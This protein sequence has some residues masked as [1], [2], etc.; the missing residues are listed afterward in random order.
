VFGGSPWCST[1]QYNLTF[2]VHD[3]T[4]PTTVVQGLMA[5]E[6]LEAIRQAFGF[7]LLPL[8]DDEILRNAGIAVAET[9]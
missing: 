2:L 5:N 9:E 4:H 7:D 8:S 3:A 6:F 1:P